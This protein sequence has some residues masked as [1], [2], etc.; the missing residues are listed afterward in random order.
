MTSPL[1]TR[2]ISI[3]TTSTISIAGSKEENGNTTHSIAAVRRTETGIRLTSMADAPVPNLLAGLA[4]GREAALRLAIVL[5]RDQA[6][7]RVVVPVVLAE[8]SDREESDRVVR[9]PEPAKEISEAP[10]GPAAV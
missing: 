9:V 1:T 2:T 4:I 3:E 8:V 5:A 7:V 6:S 10:I